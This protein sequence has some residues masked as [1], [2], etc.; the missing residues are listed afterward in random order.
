M[1]IPEPGEAEALRQ[2]HEWL[3]QQK[4]MWLEQQRAAWEADGK[5]LP[6]AEWEGEQEFKWA[7]E[8][9]H[10]E[11]HWAQTAGGPGQPPTHANQRVSIALMTPSHLVLQGKS[12]LCRMGV[13][14]KKKTF[15]TEHKFVIL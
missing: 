3:E 2:K 8:L 1:R 13:S 15:T 11:L 14:L 5:P 9:P 12:R 10:Y 4:R 7:T 6:W